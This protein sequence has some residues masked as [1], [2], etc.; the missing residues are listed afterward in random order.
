MYRNQK[1]I[2]LHSEEEGKLP[3]NLELGE[4]AVNCA[5]D[6]EFICLKNT[7]N[8]LVKITPNG[9]GQDNIFERQKEDYGITLKNF[10]YSRCIN[11]NS[12][13]YGFSSFNLGDFCISFND[14]ILRNITISKL[15]DNKIKTTIKASDNQKELVEEGYIKLNNKNNFRKIQNVE[16]DENNNLILEF[17]DL[18]DIDFSKK[19]DFY[20]KIF[21]VI[22]ILLQITGPIQLM[23]FILQFTEC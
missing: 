9:G 16:V 11:S 4:L 21:I 6:K 2:L 19:H 7:D 18:S 8:Q 13:S 15:N 1:I 10:P 17:K 14:K 22:R 20:I 12:M 23:I 5:K 3:E